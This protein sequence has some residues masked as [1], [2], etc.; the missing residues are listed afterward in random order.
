VPVRS[1]SLDGLDSFLSIA[2]MPAGIPVATFQLGQDGAI[3]AAHFAIRFLATG[4][5]K[6]RA[7]YMAYLRRKARSR[8]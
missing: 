6:L 5:A 3:A 8:A 2:Q 7:R 4:D 1:K